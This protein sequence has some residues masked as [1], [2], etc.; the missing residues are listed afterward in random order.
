MNILKMYMDKYGGID[1]D[2]LDIKNTVELLNSCFASKVEP[3]E[4]ADVRLC[5]V[6]VDT[7][8]VEEVEEVEEDMSS[9]SK[10]SKI[11]EAIERITSESK[12]RFFNL[13]LHMIWNKLQQQLLKS[14]EEDL[15]QRGDA[16]KES[17][18]E[19]ET[20]HA[21][22]ASKMQENGWMHPYIDALDDNIAIN[23]DKREGIPNIVTKEEPVAKVEI[24]EEEAVYRFKAALP[25]IPVSDLT[26]KKVSYEDVKA[27]YGNTLG[28]LKLPKTGLYLTLDAVEEGTFNNIKLTREELEKAAVG[29]S[30]R[31]FI[32]GH[33]WNDPQKAIGQILKADVYY[34]SSREKWT[35]G[36]L[37]VVLKSSAIEAFN[38]GL[39]KFVS[40]GASMRSVCNICNKSVPE[41]CK[42]IRGMYYKTVQGAK[43]CIYKGED[44]QME[45][46]SCVNV[47]A[48]RPAGVTGKVTISEA[49]EFLAASAEKGADELGSMD[50][51][52]EMQEVAYRTAVE[53]GEV[54]FDTSA[55]DKIED[56]K[57]YTAMMQKAEDN[58]SFAK[59]FKDMQAKRAVHFDK[60]KN[61]EEALM[62]AH[63]LL[64]RWYNYSDRISN[65]TSQ[66]IA[67]EH[68]KILSMLND[69][70][71]SHIDVSAMDEGLHVFA[72]CDGKG[73]VAQQKKSAKENKILNDNDKNDK[74]QSQNDVSGVSKVVATKN[75]VKQT[76]KNG[77]NEVKE[78][79]V[80]TTELASDERRAGYADGTAKAQAG[81]NK[82]GK[83]MNI[84]ADIVKTDEYRKGYEAGYKAP[85]KGKNHLKDQISK[86]GIKKMSKNVTKVNKVTELPEKEAVDS[87]VASEAVTE[88]VA[89]TET[90]VTASKE[91]VLVSTETAD[92]VET[93]DAEKV[94][95]T[96]AKDET[97]TELTAAVK[98]E[99]I[100]KVG[101]SYGY[102]KCPRCG[103]GRIMAD[104]SICPKCGSRVLIR[105]DK[106]VSASTSVQKTH[107]AYDTPKT[108][109]K[110]SIEE[111]LQAE[112]KIVK[113]H[114]VLASSK[115]DSEKTL[116]CQEK[117]DLLSERETLLN[118]NAELENEVAS[119][120]LSLQTQEVMCKT[121]TDEN[122]VLSKKLESLAEIEKKE[123]VDEIIET[124]VKLGFIEDSDIEAQRAN[125]EMKSL[126]TLNTVL[127]EVKS[128]AE[129]SAKM[130]MAKE[131]NVPVDT[132]EA[133]IQA[134]DDV[135]VVESTEEAVK[136]EAEAED[137][138]KAEKGTG[139]AADA[140]KAKPEVKTNTIFDI[141]KNSLH[142]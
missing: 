11:D 85:S 128:N 76:S 57:G 49:R 127:E 52:C 75:E 100:D 121:L 62:F 129:V 34:N 71:F 54:H 32:E 59:L 16:P 110:M 81:A 105:E 89:E 25:E 8:A 124:K 64:H 36:V 130:K 140:Q 21:K 91:D 22:L 84:G 141:V 73:K 53:E 68:N 99:S 131:Y 126:D 69:E 93:A 103:Q 43:K 134:A 107:S 45:E 67:D 102:M 15:E 38:I 72:K 137:S 79:G 133:E 117:R 56:A 94:T 90:V 44:L 132:T 136:L 2:E 86:G 135:K 92:V 101:K 37:A 14:G 112:L 114:L 119:L 96:A 7:E 65:W 41:G 33:D 18:L 123:I 116:W 48:C 30:G 27:K 6:M 104:A 51:M 26:L 20:V 3:L 109:T 74:N 80:S 13:F 98:Q 50:Y 108:D 88:Q 70:K 29:Y 19:I 118:S 1:S 111:A 46:L 142:K 138:I 106:G 23:E 78:E 60:F 122:V 4:G 47:P 95:E 35:L 113:E 77:E 115:A 83:S 139:L 87:V 9:D 125:Y 17:M 31:M 28:E 120:K 58:A 97:D 63:E 61:K 66:E 5:G 42:H 55:D 39:Y 82:G 24:E 40:I 12:A 10:E